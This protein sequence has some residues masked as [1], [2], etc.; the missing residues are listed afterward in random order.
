[1]YDYCS[2]RGHQYWLPYM[3]QNNSKGSNKRLLYSYTNLCYSYSNHSTRQKFL[4]NHTFLFPLII[5]IS[6]LDL[7]PSYSFRY[8][9][10]LII[11]YTHYYP[12]KYSSYYRLIP[13]GYWIIGLDP[14]ST[15]SRFIN[16]KVG[17]FDQ[18]ITLKLI[19]FIFLFL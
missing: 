9:N 11:F 10:L 4:P 16:L 1:M 2:L 5:I 6:D 15:P 19:I 3:H 7:T 14:P 8:D 18:I 13:E 12:L 17:W